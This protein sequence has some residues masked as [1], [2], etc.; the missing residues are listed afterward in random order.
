MDNAQVT[1][2][3]ADREA[4]ARAGLELGRLSERDAEACQKGGT[5]DEWSLVLAFARHRLERSEPV[6]WKGIES[7]P[8]DGTRIDLWIGGEYPARY[9]DAYWGRPEHTCGEAG[10]YCDCCPSYDGWVDGTLNCYLTGDDGMED[11]PTH[12]M[13]L[14]SAPGTTHDQ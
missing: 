2:T 12:W 6:G 5:W 3:Q 4:A 7:A 9:P 10:R 11:E 14:P 1:I 8:K 13:P